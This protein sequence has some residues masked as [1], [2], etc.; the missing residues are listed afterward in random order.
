MMAIQRGIVAAALALIAGVAVGCTKQA[1]APN[2]GAPMFIS[3]AGGTGIANGSGAPIGATGQG[4]SSI[5]GSPGGGGPVASGADGTSMTMM[6]TTL[7][8]SGGSTGT[9]AMDAGVAAAD[10]SMPADGG[11]IPDGMVPAAQCESQVMA[12]GTTITDCERCLCQPG[13]CQAELKALD[14]DTKANALITCTKTHPCADT[15]CL[16]G[17]MCDALGSNY[18]MGPCA[19]ELEEAA[20]AMPGAGVGNASMLMSACPPT[21]S[22]P[23]SCSKALALA[24]CV[25][26]HC[27][28]MCPQPPA[29]M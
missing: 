18:G 16:C 17:T 26:D 12:S 28:D 7:M 25:K 11:P 5:T 2:G 9:I 27:A 21:T 23:T 19:K 14:G 1:S 10:G 4:G 15:C 20:G 22:P 8:G 29:C 6:M 13:H 3:G 24:Q